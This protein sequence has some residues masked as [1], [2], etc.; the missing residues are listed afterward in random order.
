MLALN[1]GVTDALMNSELGGILA[2]GVESLQASAMRN[3]V[4]REAMD[5]VRY[6]LGSKSEAHWKEW[7]DNVLLTVKEQGGIPRPFQMCP[8]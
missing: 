4:L 5:G 2:K 3:R 8:R 6:G 7:S 1:L